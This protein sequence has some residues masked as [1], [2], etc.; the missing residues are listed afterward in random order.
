MP[1]IAGFL[2]P[3]ASEASFCCQSVGLLGPTGKHSA[4][5]K[6]NVGRPKSVLTECARF[7]I[8]GHLVEKM[9]NFCPEIAGFLWDS[10]V[11]VRVRPPKRAKE[12]PKKKG[13][14]LRKKGA[15]EE[16]NGRARSPPRKNDVFA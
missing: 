2:L 7:K 3:N 16:K 5:K 1:R 14:K 10:R 15:R 13:E 9:A 12:S 4:A 8:N 11:R 6:L